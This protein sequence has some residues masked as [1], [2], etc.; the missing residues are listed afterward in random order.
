MFFLDVLEFPFLQRALLAGMTI[1]L[2]APLLGIFLVTR[3]YALLIDALSHIALLGVSVATVVKIPITLGAFISSFI[4][5]L[6]IEHF[7]HRGRVIP[8][9]L[10]ALFLSGSLA[11]SVVILNS[12]LGQSA[13]INLTSF[14]FGSLALVTWL[15][16]SLL[17]ILFVFSFGFVLYYYRG[18]FLLSLDEEMAEVSG[19]PVRRIQFGFIALVALLV[20]LALQMVGA[21]LVGAL[22]VIPV[23]AAMQWKKGFLHTLILAEFFS[24]M[25]M[26]LGITLAYYFAL[27]SGGM[28]VLTAA[29]FF[30]V[31]FIFKK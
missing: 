3:R 24:V 17:F 25:A 10:V 20:A 27:P 21:L 28:I 12:P 11:L 22:L 31:S 30:L 9:A 16:V 6:S 2:L 23:L 8:D 18:L 1:A 5:G 29:V 26:L 19:V 15:D 14:L 13:Q 7:R 4:A